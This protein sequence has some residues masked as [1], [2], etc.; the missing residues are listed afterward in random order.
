MAKALQCP[1][2]QSP[3]DVPLDPSWTQVACSECGK[4]LKR[5][6]PVMPPPAFDDDQ[7][8]ASDVN[9]VAEAARKPGPPPTQSFSRDEYR[10]KLSQTEAEKW[11]ATDKTVYLTQYGLDMI[12]AAIFMA[13]GFLGLCVVPIAGAM[14]PLS[15]LFVATCVF[16]YSR[17]RISSVPR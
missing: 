16:F 12:C 15:L 10:Q 13:A 6:G 5:K 14:F 9:I 7:P 3:L 4:T 1:S 8:K 11:Q 17:F 2:C